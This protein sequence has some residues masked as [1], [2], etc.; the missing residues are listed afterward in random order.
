[1]KKGVTND[2]INRLCMKGK[3]GEMKLRKRFK[4]VIILIIILCCTMNFPASNIDVLAQKTMLKKEYI[5]FDNSENHE[6]QVKKLTSVEKN[7][8]EDCNKLIVEENFTIKGSSTEKT[9]RK[10]REKLWNKKMIRVDD[11]HQD[12]KEQ[13]K[14]ALIDSGVDYSENINVKERINLI[15]EEENVSAL[16]DDTN[17]H[18]T[19][20]ASIICSSEKEN[21]EAKGI[22]SNID[23][24]S[25][26]VLDEM[27]EAPLSRIIEGINRAI[28][29]DVDIISISFGTTKNSEIMH[30]AIRR[31]YEAGI[32][33]IAAS[34]NQGEHSDIVEYPAAYEETLSV[35][36]VN[37]QAEV[38]E[39]SSGKEKVDV[40]APGE[41][42]QAN[43]WFGLEY[44]CS[45]TSIAVPHVVGV[46]SAL[47][48]KGRNKSPNFIKSLI[49]VSSNKEVQKEKCAGLLDEEYALKIYNDF[50]EEYTNKKDITEYNY[51]NPN[52]IETYEVDNV[53]Q[54][55]W[56]RDN[57]KALVVSGIKDFK[58]K[59]YTTQQLTLIRAGIRIPDND[60]FN[61]REHNGWH[62]ITTSTNYIVSGYYVSKVIKTKDCD[63]SQ[64]TVMPAGMKQNDF[65]EMKNDL[66]K[67]PWDK[68]WDLYPSLEGYKKN[69]TNKR[70]IL[71]GM[72]MHIETD[73]FAHR[74]YKKVD[75]Q[76][77][78]VTDTDNINEC[79]IRYK[80]AG[81]VVKNIMSQCINTEAPYSSN[82]FISKQ[83]AL[84]ETY[85]NGKM[86]L[87][88]LVL[89]ALDNTGNEP[90]FDSYK[91]KLAKG[92]FPGGDHNK[93]I[94]MSLGLY[95]N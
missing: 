31:A 12:T 84:S 11:N 39:F 44:V 40:L 26:K 59:S 83:M 18:G 61:F 85:Y 46:A 42:V 80:A 90:A 15:P 4:R 16:Y 93:G 78:R 33:V 89:H 95:Y 8:L 37:S 60:N 41:N 45:G 49:K 67:M 43:G 58:G 74:A 36:S 81:Q 28:E 13:I 73:A 51:N 65:K 53:V 23:L 22:Y 57:H 19:A 30:D 94:L 55:S 69:D 14:V 87:L 62:S 32:L 77:V 79:N 91:V 48:S 86:Q 9:N 17:G 35:G 72:L 3:V 21:G 63:A 92:T 24:Y 6:I 71:W 25:I 47:L 56:S 34:G 52:N 50:T 10:N 38:S 75:G 66:S 76:W 27:N 5:I 82:Y 64:I 2:I 88:D 7:K 1:M 70:F 20:I 29:L 54:G 68:I